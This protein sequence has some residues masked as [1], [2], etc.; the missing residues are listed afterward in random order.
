MLKKIVNYFQLSLDD[1][2]NKELNR[3]ML[4]K[5]SDQENE[6]RVLL[7]FPLQTTMGISTP[8][9]GENSEDCHSLLISYR[10][11]TVVITA[12]R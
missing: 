2:I 3:E 9:I 5:L 4:Q 8:A 1:I 10:K 12:D 6:P 7:M 11:N